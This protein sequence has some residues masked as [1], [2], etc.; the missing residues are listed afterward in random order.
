MEEIWWLELIGY[1]LIINGAWRLIWRFPMIVGLFGA[2][3]LGTAKG[4][5][6]EENEKNMSEMKKGL[7]WAIGMLV[8]GLVVVYLF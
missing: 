5:Q 4:D 6:V 7:P 1:I 8:V 2:N 3:K